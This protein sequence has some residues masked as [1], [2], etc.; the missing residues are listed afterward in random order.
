[1]K[2]TNLSA[3]AL[4]IAALAVAAT[5][6][7]QQ[8]GNPRN[9]SSYNHYDN[10]YDNRYT[11]NES[12]SDTAQ[13]TRV[14]R[15]DPRSGAYQRQECWNEQYNRY[16]DA[17][18]RDDRG[19]LY[20][21]ESRRNVGGAVIG[22]VVGGALGTQVGDGSG[23][24]AATIAGVV[25]GAMIGS[26]VGTQGNDDRYRDDNGTVRRC[27]TTQDRTRYSGRE[28]YNVTYRY[29]GQTYRAVTRTRPGRNIRVLVN[30]RPL[31]SG[32]AYNR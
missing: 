3:L 12:R 27:R 1:M 11:D 18:Y 20:Q 9:P 30:V 19:R 24:T 10:Q 23:R 13:V 8:Y 29:G 4:A 16:E 32:I 2:R 31:D 17:Y 26:K 21:D 28:G 22:G 15:I 14:E 5:A 25:I 7:A 6:N